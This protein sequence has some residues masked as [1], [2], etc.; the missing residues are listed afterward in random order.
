M[1][2]RASRGQVTFTG[3]GWQDGVVDRFCELIAAAIDS[4]IFLIPKFLWQTQ[5]YISI[6]EIMKGISFF[7]F[8]LTCLKPHLGL[9]SQHIL[10]N[11]FA[12]RSGRFHHPSRTYFTGDFISTWCCSKLAKLFFIRLIV[13]SSSV[14]WTI[15]NATKAPVMVV[16]MVTVPNVNVFI[17]SNHICLWSRAVYFIMNGIFS[18]L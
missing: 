11:I 1:R 13:S 6:S 16:S 8:F 12:L 2:F 3:L 10:P 5:S 4:W 7:C 15:L 18:R 17:Q 9:C 14:S